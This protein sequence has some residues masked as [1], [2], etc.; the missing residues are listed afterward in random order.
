MPAAAEHDCA[1]AVGVRARQRHRKSYNAGLD[2]RPYSSEAQLRH[3]RGRNLRLLLHSD[4]ARSH[5]SNEELTSV[6]PISHRIHCSLSI[7][8]T[9]HTFLGLSI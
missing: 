2:M 5:N 3:G 6:R 7:L 9:T 8:T 1:T 4:R